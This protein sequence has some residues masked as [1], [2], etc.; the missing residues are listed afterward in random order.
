ME[1]FLIESKIDIKLLEFLKGLINTLQ[2]DTLGFN[3]N[4]VDNY[5]YNHTDTRV[6]GSIDMFLNWIRE[7][8]GK[9]NA[10]LIYRWGV[11]LSFGGHEIESV[12]LGIA[13]LTLFNYEPSE[14]I[15]E[16]LEK[17][18]LCEE[19]TMYTNVVFYNVSTGNDI[20]FR[21]VKKLKGYGKIALIPALEIEDKMMEEWL[22]CYGCQNEVDNSFLGLSIAKKIDLPKLVSEKNLTE[23]EFNG[24]YD[25][26]SSLL[27]ENSTPGISFY[28]D[29]NKLFAAI[30]LKCNLF[31]TNIKYYDL[32]IQIRK[33]IQKHDKTNTIIKKINE[34]LK[35]DDTISF[36]KIM[37]LNPDDI[38]IGINVISNLTNLDLSKEIYEVYHRNSKYYTSCI[39]YLMKNK[40]LQELVLKDW[41]EVMNL[42]S[43]K[44]NP[45]PIIKLDD[46]IMEFTSIIQILE[47]FPFVGTNIIISALASKT[48]YPRNAAINT[49]SM[50]KK[51]TKKDIKSFPKTLIKALQEL[52]KKEV[53]KSYKERINAILE[54]QEDLSKFEE[55]L[56]YYSKINDEINE[57]EDDDT[58]DKIHIFDGDIESLFQEII[59]IRGEE[60]YSNNMVHQCVKTNDK[61]IA[62]VQGSQFGIEYE[63]VIG[64][65]D[66]DRIRFMHCNCPYEQNCKH[67]YATLLH[68]RKHYKKG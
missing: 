4:V 54:I 27:N 67:E 65:D 46:D 29:K 23:D 53:I 30:L 32:L 7:N 43:F 1:D 56:I 17:L 13:L 45:E 8:R 48:M 34:I 15:I 63:I 31:K 19:F 24:V 18:S 3:A 21:L 26:V 55:P 68:I 62:F 22:L 52:N 49:I 5:F 47:E 28:E 39:P 11:Y 12:K 50:W 14:R 10:Q 6:L 57:Q 25:I 44:G 51:K 35:R 66:D 20:R 40:K 64:V 58:Q 42:D 2:E 61:Y 16:D 33:Y 37:I 60:Y 38:K 36:L 9:Y 59:M 41:L